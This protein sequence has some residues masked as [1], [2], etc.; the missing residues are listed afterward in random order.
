MVA[1]AGGGTFPAM[2]F[3]VQTISWNITK[4]CHLNCAHCYLDA[5]FRSGARVDELSTQECFHILDQIG[6]VNP[7]ALLILTG[8]EPLLRRDVFRIARRAADRG[9]LVVLGTSGT[10]VSPEVADRMVDAGIRGASISLHSPRP[11]A[12]DAFTRVPGSWA[13]AVRG[14]RI[15]R[16]KDVP[17][18]I[19]TSTMS[20]NSDEIPEMVEFSHRL[21]AGVFNL[22]FLVCTGRGQGMTDVT[23]AEY[24][25]KLGELF[26]LQK[27]YQGRMLLGAKCAPQYMRIVY[28]RDPRSPSLKTYA[29]GCPAATHYCRITPTGDLTPCPYLPLSAGNLKAQRFKDLWF[30]APLMRELRDRTRLRGRCGRCE[31]QTVCS[32]C[33]A[34]A[35]AERQDPLAEDPSCAYQTGQARAEPVVLD[36]AVTFGLEAEY[37]APWTTEARQRLQM[38]PTFAR[39]MVVK[40]VERYAQEMGYPAITPQV[41]AEA[42]EKF[43][44][45][46]R[47]PFA[48]QS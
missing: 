39:G 29:G 16:D 21:G 36:R 15:L 9:C 40:G 44:G 22:Y 24:E 26:E 35:Y 10:P 45:P 25:R 3:R 30:E 17:L 13:R 14:A 31:F 19:Q 18:I 27:R 6:E 12:H 4:L 33:R 38:V 43:A 42:R 7:N 8:G 48:R 11:E 32:G 46:T 5:D 41:M 2:E 47:F 23:P 20:W 37:T 28:Q 34:R 1:A